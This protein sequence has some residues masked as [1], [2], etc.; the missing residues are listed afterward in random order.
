MLQALS[1]RGATL[2]WPK[3]QFNMPELEFYGMIFNA[4]GMKPDPKKVEAVQK[5]EP[6]A[7]KSEVHSFL[8]MTTYLCGFLQDYST[9]TAPLREVMKKDVPFVWG[10]AQQE[11]F[12]YL[13][14]ILSSETVM[15]YFDPNSPA[16][17]DV[18]ASPVGLGAMLLQ[19]DNK[20]HDKVMAYGSC[21]LNSAEQNY[22]QIERE[23]LAVV[24]GLEHFHDMI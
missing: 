11:A 24:W 23:G 20:G 10:E 17:L 12:H 16:S 6:P 2:N 13:Q 9:I 3:C 15:A 18:D 19:A 21:S 4:E 7:S 1:D 22:P 5:M 8:G 14:N